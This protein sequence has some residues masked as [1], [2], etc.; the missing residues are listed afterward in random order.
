VFG[1]GRGEGHRAALRVERVVDPAG[2]GLRA[3]APRTHQ[4]LR[5][6]VGARLRDSYHPLRRGLMPNRE[7]HAVRKR[8]LFNPGFACLIPG[9]NLNFCYVSRLCNLFRFDLLYTAA[10]LVLIFG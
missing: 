9:V 1:V 7:T 3:L 5:V 10:A 2:V 6:Q 4:Q 8:E